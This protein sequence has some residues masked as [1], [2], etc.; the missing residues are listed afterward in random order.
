MFAPVL[1]TS[2]TVSRPGWLLG[3]VSVPVVMPEAGAVKET[4]I[5]QKDAVSDPEAASRLLP[6]G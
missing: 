4:S 3:I 2:C 6:H 1:P 5:M